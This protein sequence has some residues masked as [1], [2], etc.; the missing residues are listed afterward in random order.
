MYAFL[1]SA[2]V[3]GE[4]SASRHGRFTP[5]ERAPGTHWLGDWVGPRASLD[6]VK[7]LKFLLPPGLELRPLGP[8]ARSQWVYRLRYPGSLYS[9]PKFSKKKCHDSLSR[10]YNLMALSQTN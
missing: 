5:G 9:S 7:K 3:G 4:S 8:P 2:A 6:D 10:E 1:T